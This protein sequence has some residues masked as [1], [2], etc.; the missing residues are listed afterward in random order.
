MGQQPKLSSGAW[1]CSRA[2]GA[3]LTLHGKPAAYWAVGMW[4]VSVRDT[5]EMGRLGGGTSLAY[6]PCNVCFMS[7]PICH[8]SGHCGLN[9][10]PSH[11]NWCRVTRGRWPCGPLHHSCRC[12][13][14]PEQLR[15]RS[16]ELPPALKK[17]LCSLEPSTHIK[18]S[19]WLCTKEGILG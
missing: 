1:E 4:C 15:R 17:T 16:P 14:F 2:T 11:E 19:L 6:P 7:F 10:T 18:P 13:A 5:K 3:Q 8:L 9:P 12:F